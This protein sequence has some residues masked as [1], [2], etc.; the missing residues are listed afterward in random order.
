MAKTAREKVLIFIYVV[1]GL[2][3]LFY[4]LSFISFL[5]YTGNG[6]GKTLSYNPHPEKIASYLSWLNGLHI[7]Q[8]FWGI[9]FF[10]WLLLLIATTIFFRKVK[11]KL[12]II[13]TAIIFIMVI[14]LD[15]FSVYGLPGGWMDDYHD[16]VL[17]IY[18]G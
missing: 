4:V 10:L 1:L 7:L 14:Y 3:P 9:S 12:L 17:K 13:S 15:F 16:H 11:T 18:R 6:F 5:Y 8:N 2:S